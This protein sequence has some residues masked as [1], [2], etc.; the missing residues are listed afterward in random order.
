MDTVSSLGIGPLGS[1]LGA[2]PVKGAGSRSVVSSQATYW[3]DAKGF[4][5]EPSSSIEQMSRKGRSDGAT[6]FAPIIPCLAVAWA[7]RRASVCP[8]AH[9]G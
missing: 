4:R 2:L 6:L 8:G 5:K 9:T 7:K 3:I 1:V